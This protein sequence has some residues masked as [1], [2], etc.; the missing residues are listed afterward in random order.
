MN[1]NCKQSIN[2]LTKHQASNINKPLKILT[3]PSP[4]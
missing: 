3:Q 2:C 1:I 4:G